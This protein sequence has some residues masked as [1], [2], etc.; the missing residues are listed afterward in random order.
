MFTVCPPG[1][2]GT[3]VAGSFPGHWSHVLS[4]G[5]PSPRFFPRSLIPG[6]FFGV[7]Q[8][9]PGGV[10][11]DDI[12]PPPGQVRMGHPSPRFF[13]RS[14]IPGPFF[15]V[16]QSWP[17]GVPQD[18][19]PPPN[20]FRM[21]HPPPPRSQVRMGYSPPPPPGQ[22]SRTSTCYAAGGMPLAFTQENLLVNN[23]NTFFKLSQLSYYGVIL[24]TND[25][26]LT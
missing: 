19:I 18:D 10:P 25:T 9:W 16:S 5:Y 12:P 20:H 7:P 4:G 21:G 26:I 11:Q 3:P 1:G 17:G 14:L 2:G 22:S 23:L 13:P 15:G 6:P 24:L 8:S